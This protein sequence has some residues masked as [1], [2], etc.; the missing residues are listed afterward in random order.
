MPQSQRRPV[1]SL[2]KLIDAQGWQKIQ[3][4]FSAVTGVCLRTVD[5]QG[6]LITKPSAMPRLCSELLRESPLKKKIC[7]ECLPTFLGGKGVVDRNLSFTCQA[8]LCNFVTPL[9]IENSVLGYIILGPVV[10]VMRKNKEQYRQLGEE[11]MLELDEL[12][13]ALLEIK[14]VSFQG[15]RSLIELIRDVGE[16]T[17]KLAYQAIARKEEVVMALDASKLSRL[18]NALLEVAFQVTGADIGSIMFFSKNKDELTIRAA[19]GIP[20]EIVQN[21]RVRLGEGISGIAVKERKPFLIDENL[22]DN[23]IKGYLSRPYISSS[24]VLPVNVKNKTIGVVN[25]GALQT[26]PV[27]F[28]L[29]TVKLMDRLIDLTAVALR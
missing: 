1:L 10:L 20:E 26:S 5:P 23:R 12:W 27:R 9:R 16:Y 24:M 14:A 29:D 6:G 25:L 11:L 28:T 3:N 22:K 13:G 2:K 21:T 15:V 4:N 17:I 8:G 7:G 18:L 19:R